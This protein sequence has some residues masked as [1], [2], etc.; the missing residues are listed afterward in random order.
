[1]PSLFS[2]LR[3]MP[4]ILNQILSYLEAPDKLRLIIALKDV[5]EMLQ[6]NHLFPSLQ[7]QVPLLRR[8]YFDRQG[9]WIGNEGCSGSLEV[10]ESHYKFPV[11]LRHLQNELSNDPW[12]DAGLHFCVILA[13]NRDEASN[14]SQYLTANHIPNFVAHGPLSPANTF[15]IRKSG[16][17]FVVI[18]YQFEGQFRIHPKLLVVALHV[19]RTTETYRQVLRIGATRNVCLVSGDNYE[20][21]LRAARVARYLDHKRDTFD[22]GE[23]QRTVVPAG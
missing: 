7:Y 16:G 12:I 4:H 3:G 11:M 15:K 21:L 1:M 2:T 22:R 18:I 8:G 6:D 9:F 14:A 13:K 19:P 23:F 10:V 20:E 17:L 5:W